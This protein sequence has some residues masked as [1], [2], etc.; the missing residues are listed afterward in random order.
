MKD[1][2]IPRQKFNSSPSQTYLVCKVWKETTAYFVQC[3]ENP[4]QW[5][6][7]T[8]QIITVF[9]NNK[10]DPILQIILTQALKEE[11]TLLD[12]TKSHPTVDFKPYKILIKDQEQ[13]GWKQLHFDQWSLH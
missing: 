3:I 2:T 11:P 5:T 13:I 8:L 7:A 1:T 9:R 6:A 10:V 4:K 12:L